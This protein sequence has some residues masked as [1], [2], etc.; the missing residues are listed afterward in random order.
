[1][2]NRLTRIK[3]AAHKQPVTD[4]ADPMNLNQLK[5]FISVA[6][7]KNFTRAAEQNFITQTAITQQIKSLEALV[8]VALLIR[9]KHHVELTAAGKTYLREAR[10]IIKQSED[11]LR[12]ARLASAGVSGQITIGFVTGSGKGNFSE[13]LHNFH[14]AFP[15]VKINLTRN[16][17]SVLLGKVAAGACDIAFVISSHVHEKYDLNRQYV[18]SYPIM[19]VLPATHAL[20]VQTQITYKDLEAENFIMMDPADQPRDQMQ[21]ALLVYKRAGYVPNIVAADG[22]DE[23]VMLMVT[24]G[25]GVALMP[26]Y[27]TQHYESDSRLKI[28]PLIKE[29][30]EMEMLGFEALW[31]NGNSNPVLSHVLE[32]L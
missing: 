29:D 5:Y 22:E 32:A 14:T 10:A 13:L 21:E 31:S 1:M 4:K 19:V 28:L 7:L 17:S 26:Q 27:I 18:E 12:L 15:D 8:G 30:G 11:A 2:R 24:A 25:I 6:E 20:A 3:R 9:D 23:T 16:N